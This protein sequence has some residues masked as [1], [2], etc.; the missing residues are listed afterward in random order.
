LCYIS[1]TAY[2]RKYTYIIY[3]ITY[4]IYCQQKNRAA[5]AVRMRLFFYSFLIKLP[6][7][8]GF[9]LVTVMDSKGIALLDVGIAP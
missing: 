4:G 5:I 2:S 6:E 8:Y 7:V 3:Y 9:G 1:Y